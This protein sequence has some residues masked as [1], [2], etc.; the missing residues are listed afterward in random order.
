MLEV[1]LTTGTELKIGEDIRIV[2]RE[3]TTSG[4]M[5]VA[6]EAQREKRIKRIK[7]Y[8]AQK[9]IYRKGRKKPEE[10]GS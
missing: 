3:D 5:K 10:G 2:F 4:R 8:E 6:V 9:D 1:T 7:T